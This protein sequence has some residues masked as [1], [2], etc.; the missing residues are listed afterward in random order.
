MPSAPRKAYDW[1]YYTGSGV[2]GS[3]NISGDLAYLSSSKQHPFSMV[4]NGGHAFGEFRQPAY[5]YAGLSAS[6]VANIGRWNF[7][8]SDSVNYLPGTAAAGLSGVPGVGDLN[9]NPVQISGDTGQGTLTNFS[10]RISNNAAASLSRQLTGRTA[11]TASGSYSILRFLDSGTG[12]TTQSGAGLDSHGA[13]GQGSITHTISPRSSF[14]GKLLLLT[15]YLS[16]RPLRPSSIRLRQPTVGAQYSYRVTR[17]LGISMSAGPEW[18]TITNVPNSNA[19]SLF[20]D[21]SA[22]YTGKTMNS[23]AFLCAWHKQRLSA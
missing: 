13:T 7:V 8:L 14:G 19:T 16:K 22:T 5:S 20:V 6:Q 17:K 9:V 15:L 12:S 2:T 1:G 21:A 10:N 4:L 11:L 3:A 23:C 18:S